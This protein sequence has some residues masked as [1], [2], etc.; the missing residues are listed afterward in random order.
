MRID[1]PIQ[2][3]AR[4]TEVKV[5]DDRV[6][7]AGSFAL[8]CSWP[9]QNEDLPKRMEQIIESGG[10]ELKRRLFKQAM[11]HADLALLLQQRAGKAGQGLVLRGTKAY[12]FK[13]VF[14]TVRIKRRRVE[15]KADGAITVPSAQVWQTPEHVCITAGLRAAACDGMRDLSVR[16]TAAH[17]SERA[18]ETKL[19]SPTEVMKLVH[20]EGR[21][22]QQ[23]LETRAEEELAVDENAAAC[24]LPLLPTKTSD[25]EPDLA[26]DAPAAD[27]AL[28][29]FP[30]FCGTRADGQAE[31]SRRV[32]DGCVLVQADEV[33]VH[34]QASTGQKDLLVYTAL[35]M[36]GAQ[37]WHLSAASAQALQRQVAGLWATLG[38]HRGAYRLLFLA[39]GARW[40]RNW[41]E[42]LPL[43]GKAMILCWFH[44]QK[45]CQQLLSMACRGRGHREQVEAVILDYLWHGR[46]TDAIEVLQSRRRA[47]KNTKALDDL[48]AYLEQRRPYIPNYEQRQAAGLWI[49]SNRVEK[50]NDWAVSERCKHRGMAWAQGVHALATLESARRNSELETWR[51]TTQLPVRPRRAA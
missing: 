50:F 47:M 5:E 34:A 46:V 45:R 25:S 49:A 23:A 36:L 44:L 15:Q 13:T 31:Q 4:L 41:F 38:V 27:V 39:D 48:T 35:V 28:L 17:L 7:L 33:K 51:A 20:G 9:E 14:G 21:R 32:D 42:G 1:G 29:G 2:T 26:S 11:E 24:L 30:G 37:V 8:E 3:T 18:G 10:Q 6:T 19:L 43:A 40:I 12:P 22:L 16:D